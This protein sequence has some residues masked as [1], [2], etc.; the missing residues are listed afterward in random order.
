MYHSAIDF[1]QNDSRKTD[2]QIQRGQKSG[3]TA[4]DCNDHNSD[5]HNIHSSTFCCFAVTVQ[6]QT[7]VWK[8]L[9]CEW[10]AESLRM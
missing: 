3:G 7:P 6:S 2:C 1:P 8:T 4:D 5:I 9:F 10:S